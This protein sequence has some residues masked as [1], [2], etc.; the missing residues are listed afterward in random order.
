MVLCSNY[1]QLL[2]TPTAPMA[3]EDEEYL[4]KN[5]INGSL[6]PGEFWYK[7]PGEEVTLDSDDESDFQ[8]D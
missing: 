4:A 1:F 8:Y 7:Q 3:A 5:I 6:E 2:G